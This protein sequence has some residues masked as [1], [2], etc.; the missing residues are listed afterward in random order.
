MTPRDHIV[1]TASTGL[2]R[3]MLSLA[4]VCVVACLS[5]AGARGDWMQISCVNPD[6]SAAP[7]EG[8][9]QSASSSG[10]PVTSTVCGPGQ[11]MEAYLSALVPAPP[12]AFAQLVYT[13]PAGSS[14]AGGEVDTTLRA[15]GFGT[16]SS[17]GVSAVTR[18]LLA[19][20]TINNP[21]ISCVAWLKG[22]Q[23]GSS[24]LDY[25]GTVAVPGQGGVLYV[26]ADC[27][28][29][30]TTPCNQ[31]AKSG[32][33][34]TADVSWAH[35]LLHAP[36]SPAGSGFSGSA[37]QPG[38]RGTGHV[39]FT[40]SEPS[41]PGI[42]A[43]S[44]ALDGTTVYTAA[45]NSNGGACVPVGTDPASHA[46]EFD[47]LQPCLLSEVIDV[48]VPTSGLRD[49]RHE[50][51]ISVTDA[52][53]NSSTVLDQTITTSNPVE[54]PLAR[55][56]RAIHARFLTHWRHLGPVITE[57]VSVQVLHLPRRAAISARCTGRGCPRI[58]LGNVPARH[59]GRLL[60]RL[61]RR[62]FRAGDRLHLDVTE[63]GHRPLHLILGFRDGPKAPPVAQLARR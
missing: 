45:P 56:A 18:A 61:A 5:A 4:A 10:A 17:G 60:R 53:G 12:G 9:S 44:V 62:R 38:V 63:R 1:P 25:S 15:D 41:G 58:A 31:N 30:S 42:Y 57:L 34:A 55:G 2:T 32:A 29:T 37:L 52:A 23:S 26:E 46:L 3:L 20:P 39:V 49:G 33:W 28:N 7:S 16:N 24:S 40:A 36:A 50:L 22:C 8:W 54:T 11:P 43:V 14:L 19:A 59:V 51:A 21:F 47:H 48:P 35:L 27:A 6:G 13:P